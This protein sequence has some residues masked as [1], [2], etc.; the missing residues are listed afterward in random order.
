MWIQLFQKQHIVG[1]MFCGLPWG[2]DHK[3]GADLIADFFQIPETLFA[4]GS[5][6]F[7][8]MKS[9]IMSIVIR[10]MTQKITIC[11]GLIKLFIALTRAFSDR[12]RNGAVG[13]LLFGCQIR[14]RSEPCRYNGRPRRPARRRCGTPNHNHDGSSLEFPPLSVDSGGH[15]CCFNRYRSNSNRFCSSL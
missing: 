5:G 4:V 3:S 12:K 13:K 9:G 1:K 14:D 2:A 15:C 6:Q 10:F 7:R 8:R 11:S